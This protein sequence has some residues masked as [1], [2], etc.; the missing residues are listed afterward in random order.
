MDQSHLSL[1]T[2]VRS[3]GNSW[4]EFAVSEIGGTGDHTCAQPQHIQVGVYST[5]FPVISWR[6][7]VNKPQL[8]S[9]TKLSDLCF[10]T[11]TVEIVGPPGHHSYALIPKRAARI[12]PAHIVGFDVR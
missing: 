5:A 9:L 1:T 8:R 2:T 6:S 4:I 12:S 7:Y 11:K 10:L 3:M